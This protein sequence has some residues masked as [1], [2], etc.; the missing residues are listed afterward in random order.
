MLDRCQK[1]GVWGMTLSAMDLFK[2]EGVFS[3]PRVFPID[4][5]ASK[6][7]MDLYGQAIYSPEVLNQQ[8]IST[9]VITVPF[10]VS[11]I[12]NQIKENHPSVFEII[13]ICGLIAPPSH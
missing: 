6:Q 1:V 13:D 10:Y 8:E 9:V 5:S 12:T 11:Q 3:D 7:N 2:Y 4:I